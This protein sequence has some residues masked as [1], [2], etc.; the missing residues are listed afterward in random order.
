MLEELLKAERGERIRWEGNGSIYWS[1][2]YLSIAA[3]YSIFSRHLSV[4]V[5]MCLGSSLTLMIEDTYGYPDH[6]SKIGESRSYS[7]IQSAQQDLPVLHSACLVVSSS[8]FKQMQ[9]L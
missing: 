4:R 9:F 1:F 2:I 6:L 5:R 3:S 8:R 7:Y